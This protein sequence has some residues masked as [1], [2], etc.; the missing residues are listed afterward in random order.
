MNSPLKG[1]GGAVCS[2]EAGDGS[3]LLLDDRPGDVGAAKEG[4]VK[5]SRKVVG[6]LDLAVGEM[7]RR[8]RRCRV[9]LF[10]E[11]EG[12]SIDS[13]ATKMVNGEAVSYTHLT[14]PTIA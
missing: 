14:L 5:S 1:S 3:C 2:T 10:P 13:Q 8:D 7:E 6:L 11:K 9:V 4:G 12:V